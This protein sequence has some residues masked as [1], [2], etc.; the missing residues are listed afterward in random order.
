MVSTPSDSSLLDNLPPLDLPKDLTRNDSTPPVAP[1]A[2]AERRPTATPEPVAEAS[3]PPSGAVP[4]PAADTNAAPGIRRFAGV[5]ARLAGGSLPSPAGLDWLVEK[6]YKTVLDLRVEAEISPSFIS[7]ATRRGLRYVALP[8]IAKSVDADHVSR[9][10]AELSLADGRPLYFCDTDGSRAGVMWYI[11]RI[12]VDK[13]DADVA[14]RDAEE[15]GLTDAALLNTAR[16]YID[17]QK[18]KPVEGPAARPAEPAKPTT[19]PPAA[20]PA[21]STPPAKPTDVPRAAEAETKAPQAPSA[22]PNPTRSADATPTPAP[23]DPTAWKPVAAMLVTGLGV[24]LAYA[25]ATALPT[26]VKAIARASLPAPRTS[27]RSLPP[28][29]GG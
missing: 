10:E 11:H 27:Q 15:L 17:T 12:L 19:P 5:G 8:L 21:P 25:G 24:P 7:E 9:F 3:L 28:S 23:R 13:V 26:T 29:S 1:A 4:P 6:G 14:R 20:V 22:G 16:T 2:E 18:P